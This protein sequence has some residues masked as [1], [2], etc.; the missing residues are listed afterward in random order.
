[1][2]CESSSKKLRFG[3][4]LLHECQVAI[5]DCPMVSGGPPIRL[6]ERITEVQR[7]VDQHETLRRFRRIR[8]KEQLRI[9]GRLR[10]KSLVEAGYTKREIKKATI[11][12][13]EAKQLLIESI[14]QKGWDNFAERSET[15]RRVLVATFSGRGSRSPVT[16]SPI[17]C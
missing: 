10:I 13:L 15:I 6:G 9:S 1:M 8:N 7:T 17:K 12:S 14:R 16:I 4:V 11:D 2:K 3:F 5:G